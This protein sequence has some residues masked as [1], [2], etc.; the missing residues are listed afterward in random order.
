MLWI[1]LVFNKGEWLNTLKRL[2]REY[3]P[4][5]N[6]KSTELKFLKSDFCKELQ[7]T[8]STEYFKNAEILFTAVP[9]ISIHKTRPSINGSN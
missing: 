4:T 2:V 9:H 5:T 8:D 7:S 3:G 6:A 1:Y